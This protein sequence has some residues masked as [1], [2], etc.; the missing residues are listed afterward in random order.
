ML[1]YFLIN[2]LITLILFIFLIRKVINIGRLMIGFFLY[3]K[4]T[5]IKD[6]IILNFKN[7]LYILSF[8]LIDNIILYVIS[9]LIFNNF[10]FLIK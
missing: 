10:I 5:S 6:K 9:P 2:K 4:E 8:I 3:R 7:G 1:I